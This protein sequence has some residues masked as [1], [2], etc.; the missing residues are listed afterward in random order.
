MRELR[1]TSFPFRFL[2]SLFALRLGRPGYPH[3]KAVALSLLALSLLKPG[4]ARSQSSE[5]DIATPFRAGQMA[6]KQGDFHGAVEDFRKVLALDPGL[7]EA[8]VNLG[9]AYQ[10]LFDY[11]T[12]ARFLSHGLQ[13][14][15][16]LGG[17][18]VIVGMDYLKLGSPEKA[19]P[20]LLR[21]LELNPSS[22]DAHEA[23]A[24]YYL[25]KDN[26]Q[27]AAEQYRKAADLDPDKPE[28]LFKV[29]HE[30]LDLGARLAYRGARLY[31]DS[32]WGHRF[33]GDTLLERNRWEEAALEYKKA[34]AIEPR[35][36]GLH[37][38]LG[39]A[40][41]HSGKLEDAETEFRHELQLDS[42]YERAWLG[43]VNLQLVKGQA[44]EAPG[45]VFIIS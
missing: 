23:M 2:P 14:R 33:L 18:N 41:L 17:L 43:L 1:L 30:Y 8:E 20:Y 5:P 44:L 19:A 45:S 6:L 32:P 29:G 38:L 40:Y 36:A 28:A 34:L 21:A 22:Q 39:E 42:R 31:P 27:G 13:E 9:L 11:G 10:S 4:L 12:A 26:V 24:L 25:T 16:N 35:Q 15:P 37:T 7:L 3:V